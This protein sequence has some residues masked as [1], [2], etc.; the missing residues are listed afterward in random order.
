MVDVGG[1]KGSQEEFPWIWSR[2][3]VYMYENLRERVKNL[4]DSYINTATF[5]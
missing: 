5:H 1:I 4:K 3:I 2:Y